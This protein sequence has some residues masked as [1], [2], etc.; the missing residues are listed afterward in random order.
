LFK[1]KKRDLVIRNKV[2]H[3]TKSEKT[4]FFFFEPF[5]IILFNT[6]KTVHP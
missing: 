3:R 1:K 6:K 4:L 5:E 2:L